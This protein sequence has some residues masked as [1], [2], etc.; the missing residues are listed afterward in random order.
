MLAGSSEETEPGVSRQVC[1]MRTGRWEML[2]GE[3]RTSLLP[4]WAEVN[5][6]REAF[7]QV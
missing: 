4:Y 1:L 3:K 2:S 7:H 5:P 6:K